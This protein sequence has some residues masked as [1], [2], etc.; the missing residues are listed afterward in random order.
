MKTNR[1]LAAVAGFF[2]MSAIFLPVRAEKDSF[3][4]PDAGAV[5]KCTVTQMFS[6]TVPADPVLEILRAIEPNETQ[7]PDYRGYPTVSIN[8]SAGGTEYEYLFE[9]SLNAENTLHV[10]AGS[11]LIPR[12]YNDFITYWAPRMR[13]NA[14]NLISFS[15]TQFDEVAKL[16]VTPEPDSVLRVHMVWK[17][18][19]APIQIQPQEFSGFERKGFTL[20]EWGGTQIF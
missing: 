5:E 8:I 7:P 6:Y 3:P 19:D 2:V 9:A 17:A 16:A 20:V 10:K 1:T 18:L 11:G 12:E 13:G 15:E 14:Y 4:I